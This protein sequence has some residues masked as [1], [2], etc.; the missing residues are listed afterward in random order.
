MNVLIT[1]NLEKDLS[2]LDIDI[3]K[4]INGSFKVQELTEI[5]K[6]F[7]YNKMIIDITSI[8]E[9]N[10]T[11]FKELAQALDPDKIIF[12]LPEGTE[13]CTPE[14]L[15]H[16]INSGIYNFTTN[17]D[18][19]KYLLEKSN[20][21]EDVSNILQYVNTGAEKTT[22]AVS[23]SNPTT[24][25]LKEKIII[26]FKSATAQAGSTTL[27]YQLIK[28][29]SSIYGSQKVLALELE[30]EDFKFF[31]QENMKSTTPNEIVNIINSNNNLKIILIDLNKHNDKTLC[32]SIIYLME[33]SIIALNKMIV[34]NKFSIE[35]LK[36][37][38]VMLNKSLLEQ[39]DV[40][41]LEYETGIKFIY[42]MPPINDR[43][44]NDIII[45]FLGVINL[46]DSPSS[47][48]KFS[49]FR[50]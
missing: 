36:N 50:R 2:K 8:K 44:K 14:Y 49:L 41:D 15:S 39:K 17:I 38:I 47:S 16:L 18:G 1:N 21:Y 19:I 40:K 45:D 31:N 30:K 46:I 7:Y 11:S 43:K 22:E 3:I 12:Y 27:I 42:N 34:R 9:A 28:Q 4:Q 25:D 35:N 23:I 37:N 10:N 48:E 24:I 5:F 33:P 6:S 13:Y 32:N 29:L 26:G 20:T